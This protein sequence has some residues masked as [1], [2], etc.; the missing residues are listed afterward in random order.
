MTMVNMH[1][2]KTELSKL[3]KMLED[4][5]E[6]CILLCRNGKPVAKIIPYERKKHTAGLTRKDYI[7]MTQDEFDALND[8]IAEMFG[9]L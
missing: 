4:K 5:E 8:E 3:V 6:D 7:P 2:A 9:V 1:Q